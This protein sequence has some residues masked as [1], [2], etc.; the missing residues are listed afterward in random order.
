[1]RLLKSQNTAHIRAP[2]IQEIPYEWVTVYKAVMQVW[3]SSPTSKMKTSNYYWT[4][5]GH[6]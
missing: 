4:K 6:N 5:D 2:W 3:K 1:M